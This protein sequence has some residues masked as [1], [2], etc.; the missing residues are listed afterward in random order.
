[1]G[2]L[3]SVRAVKHESELLRWLDYKNH[4]SLA[5]WRSRRIS[6]SAAEMPDPRDER[7]RSAYVRIDLRRARLRGESFSIIQGAV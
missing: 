3:A 6:W 5:A 1:V 2:P 4:T 7:A